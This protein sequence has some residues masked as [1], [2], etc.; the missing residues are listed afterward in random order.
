[1]NARRSKNHSRSQAIARVRW[2]GWVMLMMF[3]LVQMAT[4]AE[5]EGGPP[6]SPRPEAA[7]HFVQAS[8]EFDPVTHR[9]TVKAHAP[10]AAW[11]STGEI[12]RN[13]F[14]VFENGVRQPVEDVEVVHAPLSIGVLF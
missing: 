11:N 9:V 3:V 7:E 13:G 5:I 2:F 8:A 1:M 6:K 12:G 4:G 10:V 14:V